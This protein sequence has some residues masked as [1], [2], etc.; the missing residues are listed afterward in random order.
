ML[1]PLLDLSVGALPVLASGAFALV[2]AYG[3]ES[4]LLLSAGIIGIFIYSAALI[5]EG[6]G[7]SWWSFA[8]RPENF[9]VGSAIVLGIAGIPGSGQSGFRAL[10]RTFGCYV[11]FVTLLIIGAW[12]SLSYWGESSPHISLY[13]Q[14]LTLTGSAA[15]IYLGIKRAW[16]EVTMAGFVA[17]LVLVAEKIWIWLL[18]R[19]PV[20]ELFLFA[21]AAAIA[22]LC[23]LAFFRS[24]RR[25][26]SEAE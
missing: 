15:A 13:Y 7:S 6:L 25:S 4:G 23:A 20:Y 5:S 16:A 11:F 1:P 24:R 17:A 8:F 10:Y 2:L 19:L 18:P 12:P 21:T 14:L 22:G 3:M 9:I 26:L